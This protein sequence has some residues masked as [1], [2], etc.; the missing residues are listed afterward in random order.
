MAPQAENFVSNSDKQ[1][2]VSGYCDEKMRIINTLGWKKMLSLTIIWEELD[3]I[4]FSPDIISIQ[5]PHLLICTFVITNNTM[6][7]FL[8]D[9]CGKST[10][11]AEASLFYK[12]I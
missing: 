9:I 8:W 2:F 5:D 11:A 3:N 10:S 1:Y 4:Q 7:V 6:A 12:S